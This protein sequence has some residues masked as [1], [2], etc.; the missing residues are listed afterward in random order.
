MFEI[1]STVIYRNHV[2]VVAGVRERYF[3]DQDYYE[4]R[5]VFEGTL[6]FYIAVSMAKPPT[7]RLAMTKQEALRLIEEIPALE[8]IDEAELGIS[9]SRVTRSTAKRQLKGEY[10]RRLSCCSPRDL[11]VV[12]KSAYERARGREAAGRQAMS[13]D[14]KF[15]ALAE[16][17]LCDELSV[18]LDVPREEALSFLHD[19]VSCP[20]GA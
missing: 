18:S 5:T 11:A 20:S 16:K 14:K 15:L 4:L 6:R 3:D 9:G 13:V 17:R 19:L 7:V 8:T 12:V 2:C 10:A 1:G